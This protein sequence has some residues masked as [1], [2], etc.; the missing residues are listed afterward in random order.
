[1]KKAK[2]KEIVPPVDNHFCPWCG[3]PIQMIGFCDASRPFLDNDDGERY[4]CNLGE[5]DI[6]Y[7][8][9]T[10]LGYSCTNHYCEYKFTTES[11]KKDLLYTLYKMMKDAET[12][13]VLPD[14]AAPE[15][16]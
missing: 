5:E 16:Y 7:C 3:Q 15:V 11:S 4:G 8:D 6:E 13:P 10:D 14:E 1:M 2:K 9:F 12:F